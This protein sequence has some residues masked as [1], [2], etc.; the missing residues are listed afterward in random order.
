MPLFLLCWFSTEGLAPERCAIS[1]RLASNC[2]RKHL[3]LQMLSIARSTKGPGCGPPNIQGTRKLF[4]AEAPFCASSLEAQ[5]PLR[6]GSNIGGNSRIPLAGASPFCASSLEAQRP[7]RR[8]SNIWR[9]SLISLAGASPFCASSLEAQRRLR[10]GSNI[11][12][13]SLISLA[14]A[15]SVL[16]EVP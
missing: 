4:A 6:C 5:R 7:L 13:N 11:W 1:P 15:E 10:R 2:Q 12:R 8:G 16:R 3:A 9:N 14:G